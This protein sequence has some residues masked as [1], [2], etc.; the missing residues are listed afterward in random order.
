VRVLLQD[1]RYAVRALRRTPAFS[2]A[3]IATLALGIGATT[4]VFSVVNAVL[5]QPLPFSQPER[6]V[7]IW[8]RD[9]AQPQAVVEVSHYTYEHWRKNSRTLSHVAVFGSVNWGHT[10][11]GSGDPVFIPAAGVSHTFFTTLGT[12]PSLGRT[13]VPDDDRPGA[14]PVVVVSHTFWAERLAANPRAV[15]TKLMLD[16]TP[17][18]IIGVM[19]EGFDFPQGSQL[20]SPEQPVLFEGGKNWSIDPLTAPGF[21][22]FYA[23]ARLRPGTT[24]DAA[25]AELDGFLAR[26][27][28]S[29]KSDRKFNAV[30]TPLRRHIFGDTEP[31]LRALF[32]TVSLVLF[33]ACVNVAGLMLARAIA[34]QADTAVRIS[35]GAGKWRLI[36]QWLMESAVLACCSGI[37][38][39]LLARAAIPLFVALAPATIPRLDAVSIDPRTLACLAGA[40]LLAMLIC[41]L[42]PALRVPVGV[43]ALGGRRGTTTAQHVR[44]RN[45]LV[46]AEVSIA[47]V[48][49]VAAGLFVQSLRNLRAI[50]LGFEPSRVL[51]LNASVD[52]ARHRQFLDALLDRV[53]HQPGVQ[54][55]AA[56]YL[57]PLE[58]GPIGMDT[59]VL[60]EGQ[61]PWP[62]LDF[63]KNPTLVW[64]A[65]TPDYFR[66]MGV[67]V[68]RGRDFAASDTGR[69][70]RVVI[71]SEPL[72]RRLW[73]GRDPIG[74]KVLPASAPKDAGGRE[75]WSTVVGVVDDV[76][77]R[78]LTDTRYDIY[79]P[80]SQSKE[81]IDQ[82][83]IKV[84]GSPL[85]VTGAV[86]SAARQL[87]R[88][89]VVD[90]ITTMS[91]VVER[92][93]APWTLNAWLF[94]ALGAIGLLLAAIGLYGLLAYVVT[95]RT[96]EMG[97]RMALGATAG[98]ILRLI[99]R[100]GCTLGGAGVVI[101]LALTMQVTGLLRSL[102]FE[103]KPL[104]PVLLA[105]A[106]AV[107][108]CVAA[109]AS[110]IPARRATRVDP[111]ISLRAE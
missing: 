9:P 2:V 56:M 79:A 7:T 75:I 97:V 58:L 29:Y 3:A 45:A 44:F 71:V 37:L 89:A 70:P 59:T 43:Q 24:F 21:G 103:V 34:R 47:F 107:F 22:V 18:T 54:S 15:G 51:T 11:T 78:G 30:L 14:A 92:A 101:G 53:R 83:V 33:V 68:A 69:S 1:L 36:R 25:R 39:L 42:T 80:A 57:R 98:D 63:E 20:W 84:D 60:L 32:I 19:P 94:G 108:V 86:R 77:Y 27:Q 95:E 61:R 91:A 28:A 74:Q 26:E 65:I 4:A 96:R 76:H 49:V 100:S 110:F 90:G 16:D 17:H 105:V 23:V 5:L 93:R 82:L 87:D 85:G 10:L 111:A 106:V 6:L 40:S 109:L 102:L 50:D 66:T 55:A 64:E 41:G 12:P 38:A 35:L 81:L 31:S 99:V 13:F 88:S 8:E 67:R 73:P 52:E 72:A 62:A 48:L 104:E 46:V